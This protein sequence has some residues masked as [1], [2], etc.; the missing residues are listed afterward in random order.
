MDNLSIEKLSSNMI[1][2][3]VRAFEKIGWNKTVSQ[4]ERYLQEQD[5]EARATLVAFMS[6][7]F[8]G[9][10]NLL[11]RSSY[12]PFLEKNIPEINDLNV[13]PIY[14]NQ[15]IGTFLIQSVE[16]IAIQNAS[17]EI[18]IGVGMTKGY[19]SAQ[20]RYVKMGYVP[21]GEGLTSYGKLIEYGNSVLVDDDLVL[22][23]TKSF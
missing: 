20:R 5:Q 4:Y 2:N 14:R 12:K 18:G 1:P 9:Y 16:D 11:W 13:L 8:A 21:D 10:V 23:F 6:G 7:E 19:G 15:G 17:T 22:W 3:I